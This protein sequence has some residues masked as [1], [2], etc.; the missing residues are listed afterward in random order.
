MI[1]LL[2]GFLLVAVSVFFIACDD[3][4][5]IVSADLEFWQN[6]L[7]QGSECR[8]SDIDAR[9]LAAEYAPGSVITDGDFIVNQNLS[10]YMYEM[11]F[12]DTV[13]V[14]LYLNQGPCALYQI[15][16]SVPPYTYEIEPPLNLISFQTALAVASNEVPE[17]TLIDWVLD[18]E[19]PTKLWV[20]TFEYNT[21]DTITSIRIDANDGTVL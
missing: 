8:L 10:L 17:A 21:G 4:D 20:Y 6:A 7:L 12:D 16:G 14:D 3:G 13:Q 1:R 18:R 19:F 5:E 11:T 2:F 15:E 9:T